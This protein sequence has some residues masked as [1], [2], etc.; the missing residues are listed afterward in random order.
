MGHIMK[1]N[2]IYY[3]LIILIFT[4]I[5]RCIPFYLSVGLP[6]QWDAIAISYGATNIETTGNL[7]PDRIQEIGYSP[8]SSTSVYYPI[9]QILLFNLSSSSGIPPYKMIVIISLFFS[10]IIP[11]L[12]YILVKEIYMNEGYALFSAFLTG[13]S[14]TLSGP[15]AWATIFN[16]Q[17]YV[18]F[19]LTIYGALKFK[20]NNKIEWII[21]SLFILI[22]LIFTHQLTFFVFGLSL[23]FYSIFKISNLKKFFVLLSIVIISS[24]VAIN[25]FFGYRGEGPFQYIIKFIYEGSSWGMQDLSRAH[26][27]W[28]YPSSWGYTITILG[29]IGI[30]SMIITKKVYL[31]YFIVS[32]LL[33]SVVMGNIH[34]LGFNLLPERDRKS[35]V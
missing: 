18:L 13:A 4:F 32:I 7:V 31:R 15:I 11:I 19:L 9:S 21:F 27:I 24:F 26:P 17:G 33:V 8:D 25:T 10:V 12:I 1:A 2:K 14:T 35:V 23:L 34:Y 5:L 29:F 22:G 28:S 6:L 30:I 3:L 20:A 16:L